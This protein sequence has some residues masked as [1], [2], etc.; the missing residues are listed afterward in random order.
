MKISDLDETK[1]D[2]FDDSFKYTLHN[3]DGTKEVKIGNNNDVYVFLRDRLELELF[4]LEK[5]IY[6][7]IDRVDSAIIFLLCCQIG[8][9]GALA[10]IVFK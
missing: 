10:I 5:K 7:R 9:I 6:S 3:P 4:R 1:R 2:T 8:V